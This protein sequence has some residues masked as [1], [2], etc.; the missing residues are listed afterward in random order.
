MEPGPLVQIDRKGKQPL[1]LSNFPYAFA[2]PPDFNAIATIPARLDFLRDHFKS[3]W[4][5]W[6]KLALLFLDAYFEH[7]SG[8]IDAAQ[9]ALDAQAAPH[10]GLFQ[11]CDWVYSALTPIPIAHLPAP[12]ADNTQPWVWVDY[13]FWTG[14]RVVA[15]DIVGSDDRVRRAG[16]ERLRLAGYDVIELSGEVLRRAG[17]QALRDLLPTEFSNFWS[18][19]AL[20]SSPFRVGGL[21]ALP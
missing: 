21:V 3:Y 6:D 8:A 19:V 14:E 15:L 16:R 10:G 18:G 11:R 20:P 9:Q 2:E 12:S 4:G 5:P 7:I 13:A 17:T 1:R